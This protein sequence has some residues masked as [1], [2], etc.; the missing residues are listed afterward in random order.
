MRFAYIFTLFLWFIAENILT[1]Y[2]NTYKHN[3]P[4][5]IKLTI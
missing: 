2:Q 3:K 4:W 5:H 1:L